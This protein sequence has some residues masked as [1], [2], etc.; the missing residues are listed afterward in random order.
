V[1]R[2]SLFGGCI[3]GVGLVCL[4]EGRRLGWRK[5]SLNDRDEIFDNKFY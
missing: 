5:S 2:G 4:G 3:G 1:N